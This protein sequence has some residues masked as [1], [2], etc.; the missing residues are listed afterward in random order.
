[1]TLNSGKS[2]GVCLLYLLFPQWGKNSLRGYPLFII[3]DLPKFSLFDMMNT[4]FFVYP[5]ASKH[6]LQQGTEGGQNKH[7]LMIW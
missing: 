3:C 7:L 5:V 2:L 1:M 6:K 4:I